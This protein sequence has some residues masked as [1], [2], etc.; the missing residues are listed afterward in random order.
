MNNVNKLFSVIF[1]LITVVIVLLIACKTCEYYDTITFG[2]VLM[3]P[4]GVNT[5]LAITSRCS[6]SLVVLF[7]VNGCILALAY[8]IFVIQIGGPVAYLV[9]AITFF[10]LI[11]LW[12]SAAHIDDLH[13][14]ASQESLDPK[15]RK[16]EQNELNLPQIR[17][18]QLHD[19]WKK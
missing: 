18:E 8:A 4:F 2:L 3:I 6:T 7:W 15:Q 5:Y 17:P 1:S 9:L 16:N 12:F 10:T 13:T 11:T 19:V 14:A